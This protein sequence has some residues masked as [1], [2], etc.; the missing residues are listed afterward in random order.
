MPSDCSRAARTVLVAWREVAKL[1][2]RLL[3]DESRIDSMVD[4]DHA[5]VIYHRLEIGDGADNDLKYATC[6]VADVAT[7]RFAFVRRERCGPAGAAFVWGYA[8]LGACSCARR[9]GC[10]QKVLVFLQRSVHA[11]VQNCTLLESNMRM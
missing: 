10:G 11:R 9:H 3:R 7:C 8:L 4:L 1:W 6:S 5:K 2:V